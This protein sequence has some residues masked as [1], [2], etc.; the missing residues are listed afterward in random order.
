MDWRETFISRPVFTTVLSLVI[1]IFGIIGLNSLGVREFPEADRPV[2]SVRSEYP[3]AS[4]A[5][6]ESQITEVL[7]EQ[8]NL[9]PGIRTLTSVSRQG[10]SSLSIEFGLGDDLDRAANDVRDRVS[11][12]VRRLPD[13]ADPPV[14]EKADADGDPIVF[15]NIKSDS[16]SLLELTEIADNLFKPQFE[17]ISGVG[18]VDIWGSKEYSMRI[19]LDPERMASYG[20]TARDI[21]EALQSANVELPSGRI[22]G[23]E[24]DVEIQLR[25]RLEEDP[26]VYENIIIRGRDNQV[27][28]LSDVARIEI[29][30]REERTI[31]KRDGVPMV[32]VVL[33]P[34]SGANQIEIVDEFYRRLDRTRPDLPDDIEL[35][36]GF[37]TSEY[38]RDSLREV[39]TT[40]LF[41]MVLVCLTIFFFL[42]EIRSSL[43]PLVTIPVAL[44]GGLFIIY[45]AGFSINVL[46]LLAMVLAVGLVV[47][48]AVVVLE[49][50]Y[51]KIESCMAPRQAA[52]AG[53]K[54]IFLAVVASTLS[55]VAVF[56]PIIFLDGLTGIFFKEFGITLAGIVVISSFVALTLTPMLGARFLKSGAEHKWLYRKTE[57]F[58]LNITR[59]YQTSLT[60]F[61]KA[62]WI[63]ALLV[64][65][66]MGILTWT[67]LI[68]PSEL[69]PT[70]DRGLLVLSVSGPPG[71]NFNYMSAVLDDLDERI[72]EN[73]PETEAL[74]TVTSPG[75]GAA[76]TVNSGFSRM[77][78]P[79][80][81][82]REKSQQAIVRDLENIVKDIAAARI[83]VRQPETISTGSRGLPVQFVVQNQDFEKIKKILPDL[84]A[85][86][87]DRPEFSFV[88]VDLE[89]NRPEIEMRLNRNRAEATGV[90]I[91]DIAETVQSALAG[92]RYG[93]FLKEGKQ[94]EI[95]GQFDRVYRDEP[96]DLKRV[97]VRS[98][99]GEIL[100][101][102]QFV[103]FTEISGSPVLYR[104]NR[105][106]AA[107]FSAN[108]ANGYTLGQGID[109]MQ[110][111]ADEMLDETFTTDLDGQSRE[112]RET[113]QSLLF[114][115][116]LA[117][118][119]VYLVLAAQFES[120]RDPFVI[121]LTV[122][123]ALAGGLMGLLLFNQTLNIFSQIGLIML[124]GLV[125]KNGIL[126][127]E[128]INQR[129]SAADTLRD[130]VVEGASARFRPVLM[131]SVST[132]LGILPIALG[133]GAGAES[134][135][136]LGIAVIGGLVLSTFLTLYVVP[137]AYTVFAGRRPDTDRR[138]TA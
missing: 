9:V 23:R 88:N 73:I 95:I 24:T 104:F 27:A 3:G 8:V 97:Y 98:E 112:F 79:D 18:R 19:W 133:L 85:A 110:T 61:L 17:T 26:V 29:G 126:L 38:I 39:Q 28:R 50:I 10:R 4:A 101:L 36:I 131:T 12:A 129:R 134:R 44:I 2:I 31:L 42:R 130:A 92:Q 89:F 120:F 32:G 33:R 82:D 62:R 138:S 6:I 54:E 119:L 100:T 25:S 43:I 22:E 48:D 96:D 107:T 56:S 11:A 99:D 81:Y 41:A 123:L 72:L 94:Y 121:M 60:W 37:D 53:L 66:C 118:C 49:N 80:R 40:I 103:D 30:P 75:F 52:I 87:R 116:A 136:P 64:F 71:S 124:I 7:E 122:P 108:L 20:L 63:A 109:A 35:G 132:I 67:F 91:A 90:R 86:A 114:V 68:L 117:L 93:Y 57:P 106:P 111:L 47:D 55:L 84:L 16:R 51:T 21:R 127:V 13:D 77:V 135:M 58:F 69:A 5:V 115:F 14:V 46:T 45:A 70:E 76:T 65:A 83:S 113:G 59:A 78:L 102:D 15:L 34:Q 105:F 74:L 125:T 137:A 128:F 1:V